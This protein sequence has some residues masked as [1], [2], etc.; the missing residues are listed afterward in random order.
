LPLPLS[1]L[2]LPTLPLPAPVVVG[3]APM[4]ATQSKLKATSVEAIRKEIKE[5]SELGKSLG[6]NGANRFI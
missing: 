2:P 5:G 3:P 6:R 4:M 1:T